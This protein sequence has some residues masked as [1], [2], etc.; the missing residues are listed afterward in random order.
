VFHL[1]HQQGEFP[2]RREPWGSSPLDQPNPAL[3]S[4]G[5]QLLGY[6]VAAAGVAGGLVWATGQVA[7]LAFGHTWLHVDPAELAGVLVHLREHLG[8]PQ[9]AWPTDAQRALPGPVGMYATFTATTAAAGTAAGQVLRLV[10]AGDRPRLGRP[11]RATREKSS[12]WARRSELRGLLVRHPAPGRLVLGRTGGLTG[13][14]LAA[15]DCHSVLVYGPPGSHKTVGV[16]IP[17]MLEWDGPVVST[18][19]KPDVLHATLAERRA[20][21]QVW[22]YDPLGVTGER[23]ARWTPLASCRTWHGAL[24]TAYFL[25]QAADLGTGAATSAEHQYWT[26]AGVK[27]LAPMLLAAATSDRSMADVLAWVNLREDKEITQALAEHGH[28]GAQNA[29]EAVQ[30]ATD[31]RLDSLYATAED[32]LGVYEDD[33]VAASTEGHDLDP[34]ELLAG[35]NTLYLYAPPHEQKRLRP[36]FETITAQVVRV[37]QEQ[38]ARMP[39]GMLDPRLLLALDEAG[40]VAALADLPELATTGRAQG[41][42]LLSVWHDEAQLERRYGPAAAT[43]VNGHR[44]KVFLSGLAD[45]GA[46]ERASKLIGDQALPELSASV[47]TTGRQS[48]SQST[49]WRPLVPVDELRRLGPREAI[50]VYGHHRPVKVRLR[51]WFDRREQARR[52]REQQRATR[53]KQRVERRAERAAARAEQRATARARRLLG[54]SPGRE[55]EEVDRDR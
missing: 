28:A 13:R 7:G 43:V 35:P 48:T 21:G 40:N 11:A 25:A 54:G 30:F 8:D 42:Q 41:I 53:A 22:V 4:P 14:L 9:L 3:F 23:S 50:V 10:G 6:G 26:R 5:D 17:A 51:P 32:L 38:A 37:A 27:F 16:V 18:S 24:T 33:R 29:W 31:R 2:M 15:E 55:R 49:T 44:A 39:G 47:D 36:L 12:T 52:A 19:V 34:A 20:M 1:T 45:L 46:L